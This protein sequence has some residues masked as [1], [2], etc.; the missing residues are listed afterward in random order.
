MRARLRINS[1]QPDERYLFWVL[2]SLVVGTMTSGIMA[3]T[4]A[5]TLAGMR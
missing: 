1:L 5:M 3:V 2:T 4:T